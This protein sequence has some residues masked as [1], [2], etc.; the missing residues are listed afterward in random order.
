MA[1]NGLTVASVADSELAGAIEADSA[2]TVASVALADEPACNDADTV[3]TGTK[4]AVSN[5]LAAIVAARFVTV[6]DRLFENASS[7]GS[8]HYVSGRKYAKASA[9]L[10][11]ERGL[12]D[13][14]AHRALRRI[15]DCGCASGCNRSEGRVPSLIRVG[16]VGGVTGICLLLTRND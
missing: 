3:V 2:L 12:L 11:N 8:L 9:M 7:I 5:E 10:I 16:A 6:D 1:D 14:R 15:K 13:D 4:A